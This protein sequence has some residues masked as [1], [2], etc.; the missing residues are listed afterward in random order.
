MVLDNRGAIARMLLCL[1][2]A[3]Y[4][5]MFISDCSLCTFIMTN[6]ICIS[7]DTV[8][9]FLVE[10]VEISFHLHMLWDQGLV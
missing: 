3:D 10:R 5:H 2:S 8:N 1:A 7:I 9:L 6:A 4:L